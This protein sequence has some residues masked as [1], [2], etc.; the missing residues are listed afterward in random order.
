MESQPAHIPQSFT[1][2]PSEN[3]IITHLMEEL[4][5]SK[6][7]SE[8]SLRQTSV[9]AEKLMNENNQLRREVNESKVKI[10]RLEEDVKRLSLQTP[11]VGVKLGRRMQ[12]AKQEIRRALKTEQLSKG[13]PKEEL[14][15]DELP[16]E[17][18]PKEDTLK[19]LSMKKFRMARQS[20]MMPRSVLIQVPTEED[21][22]DKGFFSFLQL[23]KR[24]KF[25][26][27]IK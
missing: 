17:E 3:E 16:K 25:S 4:A 27:D 26:S 6:A 5:K 19:E 13:L 23:D 10:D 1:S 11:F 22:N 15:K 14:P 8:E 12:T 18:L 21:D 20:F 24:E 2:N 7:E 9:L